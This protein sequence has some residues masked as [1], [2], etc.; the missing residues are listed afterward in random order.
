MRKAE[1]APPPLCGVSNFCPRDLK[2][3]FLYGKTSGRTALA[4]PSMQAMGYLNGKSIAGV[5]GAWLAGGKPVVKS[6]QPSFD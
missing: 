6:E 5:F 2:V 4:A 3:V 1:S